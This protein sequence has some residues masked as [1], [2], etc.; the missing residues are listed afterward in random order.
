[1]SKLGSILKKTPELQDQINLFEETITD[2]SILTKSQIKIIAWSASLQTKNTEITN[3]IKEKVGPLN[4]EEK[5]IVTIASSRMSVTNPYFMG[6]NVH[7]V[8]A[9][10][11]LDI[12]K[13]RQFMTLK[14]HDDIAYH[15]SCI[16]FSLLNG[17]YMCFH[18]HITSLERS[19][20]KAEA[21]DQAL[22]LTVAIA[23]IRQM[24][25]TQSILDS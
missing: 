6:R 22:R 2:N 8:K 17:G 14:I 7:S 10:G 19:Q 1:M 16:A 12:L 11:N 24:L 5:K 3:F 9:G 4:D 20:Q 15:Y 13:L 23:T 25:F 21:I 18:S